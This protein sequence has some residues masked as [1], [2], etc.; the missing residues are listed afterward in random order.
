MEVK[1]GASTTRMVAVSMITLSILL[2]LTLI[3]IMVGSLPPFFLPVLM[4]QQ[5]NSSPYCLLDLEVCSLQLS[6]QSLIPSL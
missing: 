3:L 5:P 2:I 4:D 6:T 1:H